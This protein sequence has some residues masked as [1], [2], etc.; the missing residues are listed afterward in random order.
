MNWLILSASM[1]ANLVGNLL[2]KFY[3]KKTPQTLFR[4]YAYTMVTGLTAAIVILCFG[5][6]F[7]ISVFTLLLALGF[8][9]VTAVQGIALQHA[10]ENG[11][12]SYTMV[13]VSLSSLI[14][15]LSGRFFFGEELVWLQLVGIAL[16]VL[17]FILSVN[18]QS[19]EKKGT[20]RWFF[21]VLI[22]FLMTGAVG[23]MQKIHQSG[24]HAG[25]LGGFLWIAFLFSFLFSACLSFF[26]YRKERGTVEG[27]LLPLPMLL[28]L[29]VCGVCI[30]LNNKWNLYLSGV[31]D[32]AVFFPVVNGG[33]LVLVSVGAAILYREKLTVRQWIGV[34][35][36]ILSVI[37]LCNPFGI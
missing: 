9:L 34:G 27:K 31:M 2:Q 18:P 5:G 15:T 35:C 1:L 7:P 17:T 4:S 28:L 13:I 11:P 6:V 26:S 36:G 29:V 30:A 25:E 37:L 22:A 21:W 19:G 33:G 24:E 23:V 10:I 12:L 3:Q 8:G 14:P 20:V 32:S 16:T